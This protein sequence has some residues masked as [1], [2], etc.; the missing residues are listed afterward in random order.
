MSHKWRQSNHIEQQRWEHVLPDNA[1]VAM[2]LV[3]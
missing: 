1:I 2:E 3:A